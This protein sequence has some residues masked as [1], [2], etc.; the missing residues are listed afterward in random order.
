MDMKTLLTCVLALLLAGSAAMAKTVT[1]EEVDVNPS[2]IIPINV[3]GFYNGNVYAGV[4]QF[5]LNGN[6]NDQQRVYGFCIDLHHF[7]SSSDQTYTV[8]NL[9]TTPKTG[10]A[11]LGT[12][13]AR[14]ID[15]LWAL[16]F[17][18]ALHDANE[19]AALQVAIWDIC[20]RVDN[21]PAGVPTIS[22][23]T[24]GTWSAASMITAATNYT[25]QSVYL[26]EVS[27]PNYQDYVILSIPDGGLTLLLLG[28]ALGGLRIFSKRKRLQT[29]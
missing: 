4:M 19:A 20:I 1:L 26:C 11:A 5:E 16:Y 27:N 7:S 29:S 25:G 22:T 8:N 23:Q 18:G 10:R 17:N 21:S 28:S 2:K 12:T 6:E 15:N 24:F 14:I 9:A 3:P 13:N